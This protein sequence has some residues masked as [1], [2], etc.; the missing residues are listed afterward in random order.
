MDLLV[1]ETLPQSLRRGIVSRNLMAGQRLFRQG[2][3]AAALF[4]VTD[5]RLRL[6]R[7]VG[8]SNLATVQIVQPGESLGEAALLV[9]AY[10]ETAIAETATWVLGYPKSLLLAALNEHPSLAETAVLL[11]T[12]KIQELTLRLEWRDIPMA[13]ER[14]LQYFRHLARS[15][16]RNEILLDRPLKEIAVDLGFTP[17]TLSR[18]LSRLE[19]EG[20]ITRSG[21]SIRLQDA[22]AA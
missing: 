7:C 17:E 2:D 9:D 16:S 13:R 14:L 11:L 15:A 8:E 21:R 20:A 10:P 19:Q 3:R 5:G 1:P 18:S 22:S 4:V 12:R 6:V